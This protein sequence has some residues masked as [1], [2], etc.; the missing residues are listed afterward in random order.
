[1]FKNYETHAYA[2]IEP[3]DFISQLIVYV[4]QINMEVTMSPTAACYGVAAV[5][6]AMIAAYGWRFLNWV[7][8][9]PKKM[10]KMLREQ[11]L[12]GNKYKFLFGDLKEMV[13]MSNQA[14]LKPIKL[15]DSIVPR[16]MPFNYTSAKTYSGSIFFTWMGP[17]PMVHITEPPL[18]R[19]ILANYNQFQKPRGGNPLTKMLAKG[20]ADADADQWVKH[21]KIITPAFHLEKLKHM[22]PA[23]HISCSEMISKWEG[24]TKGKSCEVDVYPHLQTMTSDV[25][26]RTAF[27][28]SYEEGRRIFELQV[29]QAKLVIKAAQS[30][31]IPGARFLPTKRNRRMKEIDRE[32]KSTIR[33][34]I[35]KRVKTM[36]VGK[37]SKEDLL[38]LLLESNEKEMKQQ[39]KNNCGLSIEEVIEECKLFYF[40]GQETTANLLVWTMIMLGQHVN[41]QDRARDEVLKV[42]GDRKPDIDGL[43]HLKVINMILHE[44]LRLYPPGVAL[45]RMIHEETKIGNLTLPS[46]SHLM[47]HLMLLHYDANIWGDD[48]NEFNPERFIDGVSKATKEQP[49][50][51][52]FGGGPRICVGQNFA[53]LEAKL[54][55]VMILRRFSFEVSP[56]YSHAPHTIITL[57]PQFGA[58]LILSEL[59]DYSGQN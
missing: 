8:L 18:I 40:A 3:S 42:F 4:F 55:L 5:A 39:G 34:L 44:V 45:G 53:M 31:Y 49:S 19:Q 28:S 21:R 51:F 10:E 11:G 59:D 1:M 29:E 12:N 47:L 32:V 2:P 17:R 16:V 20:I 33:K 25:I 57:Q 9:K 27:G 7:W 37:N 38:G 26:S 41:W 13:N 46:G 50:Y 52:P 15:T 56:S 22:L 36:E 14:K 35:N 6:V 54:A 30:M 58:Q 48:V 23:F 43:S 24:L